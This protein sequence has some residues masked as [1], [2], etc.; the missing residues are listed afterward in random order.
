MEGSFEVLPGEAFKVDSGFPFPDACD[1]G[2]L[3]LPNV[4]QQKNG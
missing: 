2:N 3:C 1:D 4:K